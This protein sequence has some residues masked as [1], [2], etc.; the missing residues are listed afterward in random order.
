MI[1]GTLGWKKT[2]LVLGFVVLSVSR[3]YSNTGVKVKLRWRCLFARQDGLNVSFDAGQKQ[4]IKIAEAR[5]V[6]WHLGKN[7]KSVKMFV[8]LRGK[9]NTKR[10]TRWALSKFESIF[11]MP[12]FMHRFFLLWLWR[13]PGW[14][15]KSPPLHDSRQ[16]THIRLSGVHAGVWACVLSA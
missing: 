2:C 15:L 4:R 8:A 12:I 1:W 7:L 10:K 9:K 13:S 6:T 5:R 3:C 14:C 16:V 11:H